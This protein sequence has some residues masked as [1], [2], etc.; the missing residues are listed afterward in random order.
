MSWSSD[1]SQLRKSGHLAEALAKAREGFATDPNDTYLQRAY[2]WVIYDLVK[3][4]AQ[5]LEQG[6][7]SPGKVAHRLNEWLSDY[8]QFGA[9]ERP[10]MLHS[11][12]L[13][14]VLKAGKAW[15]GFL[16]FAQWWGPEYCRPEDKEPYKADNG[17]LLPS[18]EMRLFYA[19]G[20][21]ASHRAGELEPQLLAW[22]GT[23][24]QLG[25]S[26][27]PDD[28]WLHYY[29]SKQLLDQGKTAEAREW[30]MPVVRRQQRAAWV[31]TLLGQT[32]E[33]TEADKAITCY[34]RAVQVAGQPQEIAN[35]RIALARLLASAER[36]DDAA[37][38]I[39]K[40][41]EYRSQNNFSVPQ[42]LTQMAGSDWFR[43]RT[44]Q[45]NVTQEPDVS[46]A[47]EA[48]AFGGASGGIVYRAGVID[49]QNAE[50]ALAHVAFS[51]DEGVVLPYRRFKGLSEMEVGEIIE[52][53]FADDDQRAIKWKK[54]ADRTLDGFVRQFDGELTLRTGQSFGFVISGNN[55][56][57]FVHPNLLA[58]STYST[59]SSIVCRAVM[60]R[61]K[62]GKQGWRALTLESA[63]D[64]NKIYQDPEVL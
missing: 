49:N 60:G 17:K 59:G 20:R 54:S 7:S 33:L 47:A 40:A 50:K 42:A 61:D 64:P 55:E 4:E 63:N 62:Q 34:F 18:M 26:I 51:I 37:S 45:T 12:L 46:D 39:R 43:S 32:F 10:G 53:G 2:G 15:P 23:Q 57:I 38:Q 52:V 9:S 25:L 24:L 35:T 41:L 29:K 30:L 13:T 11:L 31:W 27:A 28:Q 16:E 14:Q 3:Q 56:R 58:E 21:E 6:K 36:F 1:V 48:I 5:L 19:I 22:A 8:R 44:N